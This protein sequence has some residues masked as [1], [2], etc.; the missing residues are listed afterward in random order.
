MNRERND[1]YA[2]LARQGLKGLLWLAGIIGLYMAA[3]YLLPDNW[4]QILKPIT[5]SFPFT[6]LV[7]FFSES[8]IGIIPAE[9]FVIWA[10]ADHSPD[11]YIFLVSLLALLSY[12]AGIFAFS[13]GNVLRQ[14]GFMQ[15]LLQKPSAA[16]YIHLYRRWGGAVVA[17]AALTPLPYGFISLVSGAFRFP[18][19]SYL[20]YALFRFLRFV[21][22]G[23]A[24]WVLKV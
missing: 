5:A 22:I 18:F 24:V 4:Q 20:L 17:V 6:L 12:G 3:N 8:I 16:E 21:I 2:F 14:T 23:Y 7:F 9:F 19:R 13:M 15:N 11:Q 10:K 1:Y